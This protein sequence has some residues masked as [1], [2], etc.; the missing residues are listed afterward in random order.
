MRIITPEEYLEH[1]YVDSIAIE[2]RDDRSI[3]LIAETEYNQNE[4]EPNYTDYRINYYNWLCP[5]AIDRGFTLI[6]FILDERGARLGTIDLINEADAFKALLTYF[7]EDEY[8]I[9]LCDTD[10][11]TKSLLPVLSPGHYLITIPPKNEFYVLVG[12]C[13]A[14]GRIKLCRREFLFVQ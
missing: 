8:K 11:E 3:L 13:P 12:R 10:E 14:P 6:D 4:D 9:I 5:G 2:I 1:S 7:G